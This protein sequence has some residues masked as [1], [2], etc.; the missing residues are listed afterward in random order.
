MMKENA[1]LFR[2]YFLPQSK[3]EQSWAEL[4]DRAVKHENELLKPHPTSSIKTQHF[5]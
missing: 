4:N 1:K 3:V 2:K 5:V